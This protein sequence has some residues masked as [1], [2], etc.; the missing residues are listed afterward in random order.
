PSSSPS[1]LPAG[2]AGIARPR[3]QVSPSH[4]RRPPQ[5]CRRSALPPLSV[6]AAAPPLPTS[7]TGLPF[8]TTHRQPRRRSPPR[9]RPPEAPPAPP[10]QRPRRFLRPSSQ[11]SHFLRRSSPPSRFPQSGEPSGIVPLTA[12]PATRR[13]RQTR[14]RRRRPRRLVSPFS[15]GRPAARHRREPPPAVAESRK[16]VTA[17]RG[18]SK[19]LSSVLSASLA[20]ANRRTAVSAAAPEHG[21][22]LWCHVHKRAGESICRILNAAAAASASSKHARDQASSADTKTSTKSDQPTG[23]SQRSLARPRNGVPSRTV[24]SILLPA[25]A[26]AHSPRSTENRA[27]AARA[28][29]RTTS[30]FRP[31]PLP[32]PATPR[33]A[34]E[35]LNARS[36]LRRSKNTKTAD[37]DSA[38]APVRRQ[39]RQSSTRSLWSSAP[40][41]PRPRASIP[42]SLG[43][44]AAA[45]AGEAA[46]VAVRAP[47]WSVARLAAVM[48]RSGWR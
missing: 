6:T 24:S 40:A 37:D 29:A 15:T 26:A 36:I 28:R 10:Q 31:R 9:P 4:R 21:T 27:P 47:R 33:A 5:R 18:L 48:T 35:V 45:S 20:S 44:A 46:G 8:S 7:E 41:P 25:A 19:S 11:R 43:A 16:A 22:R 42:P 17:R 34:L 13:P 23:R 32:V 2:I 1:F 30:P 39:A 38:A 14:N 12:Q 3:R